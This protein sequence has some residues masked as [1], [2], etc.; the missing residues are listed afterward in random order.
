MNRC[1]IFPAAAASDGSS[2][3]GTRRDANG[4]P[5]PAGPGPAPPSTEATIPVAELSQNPYLLTR[6][7][8]ASERKQIP[9]IDKT[10]GNRRTRKSCW[11]K[12]GFPPV[13][14][15]TRLR[16][17]PDVFATV[18]A[19]VY[20]CVD[21]TAGMD[22]CSRDDYALARLRFVVFRRADPRAT[23]FRA[24][25]AFRSDGIASV[26]PVGSIFCGGG[27]S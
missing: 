14:C 7:G 21:S 9:R 1:M 5:W 25:A 19:G 17:I 13:R 23:G 18:G 26:R 15:A 2:I 22:R 8:F 3:D 11:R 27:V 6:F 20:A 16:Y 12:V 24:G 4:R 10:L